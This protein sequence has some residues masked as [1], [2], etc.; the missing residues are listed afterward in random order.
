MAHVLFEA[1]RVA[2][3][4]NGVPALRDGRLRLEAGSVHALCG[5]NG[6]GKSTFLS[7]LMGI[8]RRDGGSM[9]LDGVEVDFED[10]VQALDHRI[11][12]IT[13]ELSPIPGMSVAE[14]IYL[15]REPRA[16]GGMID[17]RRMLRDA[18]ALLMRLGF[19]IEPGAVMS[20]LS[21]GQ[22]QLVEI[23]RAFSRDARILIMDEPT[24]AIGERETQ[25]FFKAIRQITAQGVGIVYVTHRLDEIF[26][27]ADSYT[28]FRDGCFIESGRIADIDRGGLVQ[29]IVGRRVDAIQARPMPECHT[30]VLEVQSLSRQA[31]FSDVS[32]SVSAGEI[33]GIYGLMGSG[34]S[35]FLNAV[36]GITAHEAGSVTMLGQRLRKGRPDLAIRAGMAM[37]TEDRK[38]SGLV[39]MGSVRHNITLPALKRFTRARV[40]RSRMERAHAR[41]MIERLAIKTASDALPVSTMSGGNQQKVVIARCLST[42]PRLLICDEPTRGIDEGA[43]QEVYALL[44]RF[45]E[46]GGAVL[47]VSSEAPEILQLSDRILVFRKGRVAHALTAEAANQEVLLHAAA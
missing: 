14:N 6:A 7:I 23:A 43:K 17:R 45:A 38:D 18:Q 46:E 21:L 32:L 16:F 22:V 15:G 40:L 8:L 35:E 19:D 4:F 33:V 29:L 30:T 39:L 13:Q 34:R 36:Y 27:I 1:D 41:S 10:P 37:I 31:E 25:A 44:R 3:S 5:G 20:S 12:I 9:R 42:S 26:E 2:K 47:V 24:S 11:A 28:V